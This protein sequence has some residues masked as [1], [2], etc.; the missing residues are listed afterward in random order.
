MPETSLNLA[1]SGEEIIQSV[2]MKLAE[3]MRRDCFLNQSTAYESF[4]S[5]VSVKVEMK[6]LG[7]AVSAEFHVEQSEGE[8]G[9]KGKQITKEIA[10]AIAPAPPNEVRQEAGLPIPTLTQN[11]LTGKPEIKAVSYKKPGTFTR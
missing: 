2:C 3:T 6:D 9:G 10:F 11:P 8:P 1:L 4:K 5:E 7:R